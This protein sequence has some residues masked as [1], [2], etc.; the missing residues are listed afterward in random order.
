M[1][2]IIRILLKA[3]AVLAITATFGSTSFAG[4]FTVHQGKRY[5]ATIAL[6][7]V[8]QFTDNALIARKFRALGFSK[9][10]VSGA[11]AVRGRAQSRHGSPFSVRLKSVVPRTISELS[12]IYT[13]RSCEPPMIAFIL[14]PIMRRGSLGGDKE[15]TRQLA[16]KFL[17]HSVFRQSAK[18]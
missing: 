16:R 15:W 4:E 3:V 5:R 14:R 9:V 12:P 11:G 1:A 17:V 6:N 10:R 7:S 18:T 2:N 8:E 13:A